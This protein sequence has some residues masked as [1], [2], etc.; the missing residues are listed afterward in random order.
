MFCLFNMLIS[1]HWS[2]MFLKDIRFWTANIISG[3]RV[4]F[5]HQIRHALPLE[6]SEK[7]KGD[8]G[9]IASLFAQ[10]I[11]R[12]QNVYSSSET[13][14]W[15]SYKS[16]AVSETTAALQNPELKITCGWNVEKILVEK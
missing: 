8:A 11:F 1:F 3:W 13:S 12:N 15:E 2:C 10:N 4:V 6:S 16:E 9:K 7:S 14:K 5:N